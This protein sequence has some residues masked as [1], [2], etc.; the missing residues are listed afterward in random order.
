M[1]PTQRSENSGNMG[2]YNANVVAAIQMIF[3]DG[4]P[5]GTLPV[6]IPEIG[7]LDDGSLG[8]IDDILYDLGFADDWAAYYNAA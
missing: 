3:G 4:I 8:Y 6:Q 7:I 5:S 1:D 2:S